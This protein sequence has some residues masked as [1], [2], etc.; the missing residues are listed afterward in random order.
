MPLINFIATDTRHMTEGAG[1][2]KALYLSRITLNFFYQ[3]T[4]HGEFYPELLKRWLGV[5]TFKV[6]LLKNFVRQEPC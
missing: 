2:A 1:W 5:L 4:H 6:G 3:I